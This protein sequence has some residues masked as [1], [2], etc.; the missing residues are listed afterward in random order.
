MLRVRS[1]LE[2][3]FSV[4]I[5]LSLV[6]GRREEREGGEGGGGEERERLVEGGTGEGRGGGRVREGLVERTDRQSAFDK[7]AVW[8][9]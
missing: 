1:E 9:F 5:E 7:D 2:F 4:L 8:F 6:S 3:E